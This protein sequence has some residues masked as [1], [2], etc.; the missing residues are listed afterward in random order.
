M[1]KEGLLWGFFLLLASS[2][3]LVSADAGD[4]GCPMM[5]GMY[6][7]YGGVGMGIFGTILWLLVAVALVLLIVWLVKQVQKK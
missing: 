6:S 5:G 3:G 4:Y 7:V 1:K 2:I